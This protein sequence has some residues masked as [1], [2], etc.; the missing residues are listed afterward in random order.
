MLK[1]KVKKKI[2]IN[3]KKLFKPILEPPVVIPKPVVI[4]EKT[5]TPPK[6]DLK[7]GKI[8]KNID[9]EKIARLKA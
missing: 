7:I 4:I 5:K 2:K 1:R 8:K 3:R 9:Y 6:P